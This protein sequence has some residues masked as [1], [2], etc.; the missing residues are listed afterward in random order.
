MSTKRILF[1][2]AV[3]AVACTGPAKGGLDRKVSTRAQP[4][5]FRENGVS[6]VF[7]VRCASLDCHGSIARN[8]RLYSSVGLRLDNDAGN[9]PGAGD[10]TLDE[11][12][13]NYYSITL[14]EPE[15]MN[16]VI[17]GGD[18]DGLLLLKKP[19]GIEN[20][21]GG[22]QLRREDDAY[23]CIRSWLTEDPSDPAKAINKNACTNAAV[24]P[25]VAGP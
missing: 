3:V 12:N 5:S 8:L 7:E 22:A 23:T 6:K 4:T 25:K 18:P 14:L 15:L 19:L 21:K 20:H 11:V 13:D 1:V 9:V 2:F 16:N 10:T 24:Y 17:N